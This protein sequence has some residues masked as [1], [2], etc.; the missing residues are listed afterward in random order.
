MGAWDG[1]GGSSFDFGWFGHAR[2]IRG[3]K[4]EKVNE[5]RKKIQG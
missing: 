2:E 1:V 4:G 3:R 5:S